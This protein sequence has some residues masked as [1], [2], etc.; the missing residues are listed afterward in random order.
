MK[1]APCNCAGLQQPDRS[2]AIV[3]E[4]CLEPLQM[5]QSASLSIHAGG[6]QFARA[7]TVHGPCSAW[8]LKPQGLLNNGARAIHMASDINDP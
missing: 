4:H 5:E 6:Y 7:C 3:S 1:Q 8:Y 2:S